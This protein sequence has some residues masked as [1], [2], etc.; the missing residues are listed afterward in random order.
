MPSQARA[1][2]HHS[3][4]SP[5][6]S[7]PGGQD[8]RVPARSWAAGPTPTL[9]PQPGGQ[10]PWPRRSRKPRGPAQRGPGP[11]PPAAG[12]IVPTAPA[13]PARRPAP[14]TCRPPSPGRVPAPPNAARSTHA[15]LAAALAREKSYWSS[16]LISGT[17]KVLRSGPGPGGAASTMAASGLRAPVPRSLGLGCAALAPGPGP[18]P[19]PP[20]PQLPPGPQPSQVRPLALTTLRRPRPGAEPRCAPPPALARDPVPSPRPAP[21]RRVGRAQTAVVA[22][23]AAEE[24]VCALTGEDERSSVCGCVCLPKCISLDVSVNLSFLAWR[25]PMHGCTCFSLSCEGARMCVRIRISGCE[26]GRVWVVNQ[27]I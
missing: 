6:P 7:S 16:D 9:L 21:R 13:S 23:E 20:P 27:Y 4:C 5:L 11:R 10:S 19:P 17:R 18:P 1:G 14:R 24:C 8:A 22:G 15:R 3:A 25:Q 2:R 26:S 12:A